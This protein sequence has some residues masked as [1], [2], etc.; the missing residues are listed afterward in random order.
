M[1]SSIL[2]ISSNFTGHGHK[3]IE[4]SLNEKFSSIKDVKI[5]SVDGFLLGGTALLDMAKAYGP[6]TRK[7]EGLWKIIWDISC[8]RPYLINDIIESMIKDG[9]LDLLERTKPDL[10]LTLHPNFNGSVL[11]ILKKYHITI[12]FVTLIADLVS[13]S[14]LWADPRADYIISP[15]DEAKNRCMDFGV[16]EEKIKVLGF[17]VRSRFYDRRDKC[18]NNINSKKD[19]PFRCIIMSGG[20]GVGN[21]KKIAQILLDNFNCTVKIIAGRNT[22]LKNKLEKSLVK[23]YG[24]KVKVYGFTENIQDLME[25]SDIAITRGSPNVIMEA[26]ACNT[27]LIITGALPGQEEENPQFVEKY[28]LGIICEDIKNMRSIVDNLIS[29]NSQELDRIRYFQRIYANP[30]VAENIVDFLLNIKMNPEEI[31]LKVFI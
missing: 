25:C 4:E 3:S 13:I 8:V 31:G 26:I 7:S 18:S 6:I 15:T 2:V 12:P 11:N 28:N 22:S 27:P 24:D 9:F 21:M 17:P 30:D 5:Y 29:N 23:K 1:I 19:E 20:E 14:P 16:P 10:I